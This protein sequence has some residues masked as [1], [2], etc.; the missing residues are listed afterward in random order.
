MSCFV[1]PA[2]PAERKEGALSPGCTFVIPTNT[3]TFFFAEQTPGRPLLAIS[4]DTP[5]CVW[6]APRGRQ[7]ARARGS[8]DELHRPAVEPTCQGKRSQTPAAEQED[9][10]VP[11]AICHDTPGCLREAP[12]GRQLAWARGSHDASH[13]PAVGPTCQGKRSQT[14]VAKRTPGRPPLSP[15]THQGVCGSSQGDAN[16]PGQEAPRSS[17]AGF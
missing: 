8:H 12:R 3:T 1:F 16:L 13:R 7:L 9:T 17:C 15:T 2:V 10:R 6:E 4:H 5:G 11:A 14:P